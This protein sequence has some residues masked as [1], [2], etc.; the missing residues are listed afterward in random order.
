VGIAH[1]FAGGNR[2][3]A[4]EKLDWYASRWS[5][6]TYHKVLKSGR[7]AERLKL[8]TAD[9]LTN[10]LAVFCIIGWRVFGLTMSNRVNP[11]A[12]AEMALTRPEI[13]IFDR[14]ET[15][16]AAHSEARTPKP[17][18]SRYLVAIAK[19]GGYL[20]RTN[21]PPPGNTVLWRG[22]T[23]LTDIHLG[24]ELHNRVVG[25]CKIRRAR[26]QQMKEELGL[27]HFEG[28]SWRGF[29]HHATMVLLAYGFLLLEQTRP[30][31]EHTGARKK[32]LPSAR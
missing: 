23:R 17:T 21:D 25:N 22:L 28:R 24:Y 29:H 20:G 27:D 8:R 7:Q 14:L 18:V 26:T 3:S 10:L 12:P 9:R 31:T 11:D 30:R 13:Q 32:G 5:I 15:S 4:I 19:L 6:E 1:R 2:P 16:T